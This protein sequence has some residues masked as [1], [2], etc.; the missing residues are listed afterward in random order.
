[1][2]KQDASHA[3]H[4]PIIS[5]PCGELKSH[6][7]NTSPMRL[8]ISLALPILFW[9][10]ILLRYSLRSG[11]HNSS[12][13]NPFERRKQQ[14]PRHGREVLRN[15][16]SVRPR[17]ANARADAAESRLEEARI[18]VVPIRGSHLLINIYRSSTCDSPSQR[19]CSSP[20]N[21]SLW[22]CWQLLLYSLG[23]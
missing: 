23:V 17:Q 8:L 14:L 19:F 18:E 2:P 11:R 3:S 1:M 9:I 16:C 15:F 13:W 6:F 10:E 12:A 22:H 20:G 5:N 4:D 21:R 7:T